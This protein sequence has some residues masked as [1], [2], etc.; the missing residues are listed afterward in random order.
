MASI[1]SVQPKNLSS[2][3]DQS[4]SVKVENISGPRFIP[5]NRSIFDIDADDI[6]Q[7]V[8]NEI[9]GTSNL[10]QITISGNKCKKEQSPID[11]VW[12]LDASQSMDINTK[13]GWTSSNPEKDQD[14]RL[15][16]AKRG[17]I[18]ACKFMHEGD[19][20]AV[21]TFSETDVQI[22]ERNEM[23]SENKKT[24]IP[25]IQ[26]IQSLGRTNLGASLLP[27][28]EKLEKKEG[29]DIVTVVIFSDGAVNHG[30]SEKA[31]VEA[32]KKANTKNMSLYVISIG[33]NTNDKFLEDLAN[34]GNGT[35]FHI[36]G[37]ID[38]MGTTLG[39]IMGG[40]RG[41]VASDIS[42]GGLPSEVKKYNPVFPG[43]FQTNQSR[44]EMKLN[45]L[46]EDEKKV[47]VFALDGDF[48]Q[49]SCK[50]FDANADKYITI[51]VPVSVTKNCTEW[52]NLKMAS[53][54]DSLLLVFD[55]DISEG[56][57]KCQNVLQY[58]K[59][60]SEKV[61][62]DAESI[63]ANK[64]KIEALLQTK[65][66]HHYRSSVGKTT[67]A[68]SNNLK[69]ARSY[70]TGGRCKAMATVR[71]TKSMKQNVDDDVTGDSDSDNGF[72]L[73]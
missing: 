26:Q 63:D 44:L 33:P 43:P 40:E 69:R 55:N 51:D 6:P 37:G 60:L 18:T 9:S 73:V 34:A 50:G 28:L 7:Y 56:R 8:E 3:S 61:E 65:N 57:E 24:L 70:N 52:F 27:L 42:V 21:H 38:S 16:I 46:Q 2:N 5:F 59:L 39:A 72:A 58:M 68:Y 23:K 11:S 10:Y 12:V 45:N 48:T 64:Q 66:E 36:D 71:F 19:F 13:T 53:L 49:I 25:K 1:T 30:P 62:I 47:G 32:V 35:F 22:F 4:F 17:I 15:N 20:A 54:M 14:S 31:L 29:N 67:R 41:V